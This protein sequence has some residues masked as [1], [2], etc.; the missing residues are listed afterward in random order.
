MKAL[1]L[2]VDKKDSRFVAMLGVFGDVFRRYVVGDGGVGTLIHRRGSP[3]LP[4]PVTVSMAVTQTPPAQPDL[5]SARDMSSWSLLG[6][7][8]KVGWRFRYSA[9]LV[10]ALNAVLRGFELA[11]LGMVGVGVDFVFHTVKPEAP[12]PDW[13]MGLQPPSHWPAMQVIAVI[14]GTILLVAFVK[15]FISYWAH[16]AAGRLTHTQIVVYLRHLVYDKL[17]R[18]SFRFYDANETG[19]IINRV[20]GD[21]QHVRQFVDGVMIQVVLLILTL[22]FYLTYMVSI[23]TTLTLYCLATTPVLAITAVVFSRLVKPAYRRNRKLYDRM[24]TVL[25]E[26]VQG[27][28]VVKGFALED[29]QTEK[30]ATANRDVKEQQRWIFR[31]V[32]YFMPGIQFITQ[33]NLVILLAYGGFAY[34]NNAITIGN[35][36]IFATLLQRF[37]DQVASTAQ[38]ANSIQMSLISAQRVFE[39]LDAPVE[40]Q[41]PREPMPLKKARGAV[42]FDHVTFGYHAND[43]VLSDVHFSAEPGQMIAIVGATGSGKS[44]LMSLIPRFYDPQKGLVCV[45]GIDVRRY[46]VDELRRNV[47]IVFQESFLFSNT[48]AANIA[49]GHPEATQAQIEKAATIAAAHEFIKELPKGYETYV[50]ERGSNLSGG[51]KQRLAIARA[52]LLEPSILLLDDPTAAIDPQTEHEIMAAMDSAMKNRTTFVVAH[53]LSTLQRADKIIVLDH[54]R[55]VQT[56]THRELMQQKG[57]YQK[58]AQLQIADAESLMLLGMK[59]DE[60]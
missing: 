13:P 17:Q 33:L 59:G 23:N 54:G 41:S 26:N 32:G 31:M 29:Q 37:S 34:Y 19:S 46:D 10:I 45:D 14:A 4:L 49:F 43:P 48:V 9:L 12:K 57:H 47:G 27:I 15:S 7:M 52:I 18:L 56:G 11:G 39:V 8:A 35:L 40:I 1:V 55:I 58:A 5:A 22:T 38:I 24:I 36:I 3:L 42:E 30:F 20:T 21:V 28:H 44:T 50:G 60:A 25:S 2:P 53:R 51:Q 16:V 6:R